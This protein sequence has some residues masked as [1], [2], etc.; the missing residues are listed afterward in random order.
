MITY[1]FDVLK[2]LNA[3][4]F[5]ANK[6]ANNGVADKY[7]TLKILYF[8]EKRHLSLYGRLITDDRF[9]ALKY[10]PVPSNSYDILENNLIYG[11]SFQL[12]SNKKIHPL[13]SPDLDYLS[14]SDV[15]CL[16]HAIEENIALDFQSLMEKSHDNAYHEA[17]D[18][19][20]QYMN[21]ESIAI[22]EGA[23]Q[24]MLGF[25][26]EHYETANLSSWLPA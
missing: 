18:S 20:L 1:K 6:I 24:N 2:S 10:G 15:E 13:T 11:E 8:A 21:I 7:A 16:S 19:G 5:I 23:D 25:I 3:L 4:L 22:Q 9:A 12:V 17:F 14:E 26:K